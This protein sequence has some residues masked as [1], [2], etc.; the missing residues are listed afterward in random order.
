MKVKENLQEII[1]DNQEKKHFIG[2]KR[3]VQIETIPGKASICIGVRRCGKS[4]FMQQQIERLLSSGTSRENIVLINF[5]DDRLH[6]IDLALIPEVYYSLFP[7]KKSAEIVYFFFDEIQIVPQWELFVERLMR[8]EQCQVYITGSSAQMLSQEIATQM[9][10]RSLSWE[11]FPFSFIEYLTSDGIDGA[12]PLTTKRRLEIQNQFER[13]WKTG[14]FPEAGHCSDGVRIKLHQEYFQSILYRD[15]ID[16]HDI[17]HPKALKDLAHQ[18]ID[19]AGSF[20]TLNSLYGFLKGLGHKIQKPTVGQYVEWLE[21][22]YFLFSV[23]LFD[24]S[25]S[26]S[27]ANPKKVYMVDHAMIRSISSAILINSGHILENLVFCA[28]RRTGT[29]IFY[30]RTVSGKEVDFITAEKKLVQVCETLADPKTRKRELQALFEAMPECDQQESIVVTRSE[31]ETIVGETG[32]VRVIPAWQFLIQTDK[33]YLN[34][35]NENHS[36]DQ[37]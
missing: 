31:S 32:T 19:N 34:S 25:F 6:K 1:L 11:L 15:L 22:S 5:F 37:C 8:T 24:A 29:A 20:Y 33:F 27:N 17:A 13:Y 10:G 14:G 7:Q 9:R 35:G 36:L 2:T 30:Y 3:T 21:D 18:L 4:V 16:R 28:L 26:R 23:R 12:L